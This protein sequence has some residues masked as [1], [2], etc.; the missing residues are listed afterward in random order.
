MQHSKNLWKCPSV[1][2]RM[3]GCS[4]EIIDMLC[5]QPRVFMQNC[6]A[7]TKMAVW[8]GARDLLHGRIG[9]CSELCLQAQNVLSQVRQ[10]SWNVRAFILFSEQQP[11]RHS[12]A[13]KTL[14]VTAVLQLLLLICTPKAT[15]GRSCPA[16]GMLP[17][18][19]QTTM[20]EVFDLRWFGT[21]VP[22]GH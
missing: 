13:L 14:Q 4:G 19:S 2:F 7:R 11:A 16:Q 21:C 15:A 12:R 17:Q 18:S 3:W 5:C 9:L 1:C 20:G 22:P 10:L 8:H 6:A